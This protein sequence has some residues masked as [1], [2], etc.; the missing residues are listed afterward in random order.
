MRQVPID[1]DSLAEAFNVNEQSG[2]EAF[3]NVVTGEVF[4]RFPMG[5]DEY[6]PG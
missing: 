2:E 3:L 1:I 4:H 5:D 6:A